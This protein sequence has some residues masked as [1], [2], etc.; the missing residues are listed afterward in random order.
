M[1]DNCH[2]FLN[3]FNHSADYQITFFK[4]QIRIVKLLTIIVLLPLKL[5]HILDIQSEHCELPKGDI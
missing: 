5:F 3:F 4:V 1:L 2:T